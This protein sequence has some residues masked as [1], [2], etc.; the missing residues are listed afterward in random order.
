MPEEKKLI[1]VTLLT[2]YLGAGKTTLLNHILHNQKGYKVA[3][4][5]NDIG[6]VNIDAGMIEKDASIVEKDSVVPL[7]NGCICCTLKT[8]LINQIL[9][10]AESGKY[11]YILIEASGIC[12]P[13]PIAQ[14]ICILDGT[15]ED[16]GMPKV[17]RLDNIVAV[18]DALRLVTEFAGG[19]SLLREKMDEEDIANLL[20][21]QIE[22][23]N[24]ILINKTDLVTREQ[25][26]KVEAVIRALQPSAKMIETTKGVIDLKEILDTKLFDFEKVFNTAAWIQELDKDEEEEETP[27]DHDHD[28]D[29][30]EDCKCGCKHHHHHGEGETEEYGISTFV[31]KRR[32]P[33][34]REKLET[35]AGD[36]PQ[37]VIRSKGLVWF[38]DENDMAY[39]LEQ[40]GRQITAS[41]SGYWLATASKKE[42]EEA[43]KEDPRIKKDWDDKVGDREIKLVFIGQKMD[44][45]KIIRDL[46]SC[47][48]P[49]EK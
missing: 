3:V 29:H 20:V 45:E 48:D 15:A 9:T 7:Q 8:D 27:H 28:H 33:F 43:M 14:S 44:K 42:L 34:N 17:V 19:D 18:V 40:A 11:D 10:L 25:L 5:V 13:I 46:D 36:W 47:L 4:I 35:F 41:P 23:C 37:G 21:Q 12:E 16:Q 2:G 1:P 38:S 24:T 31:Y 49:F 32:Q 26:D 6:E 39:I 22:F 30:G